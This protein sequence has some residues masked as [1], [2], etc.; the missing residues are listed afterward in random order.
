M[1]RSSLAAGNLAVLIAAMLPV[2]G[3]RADETRNMIRRDA[4]AGDAMSQR[5]YAIML[6]YEY[7]EEGGHLDAREWRETIEPEVSYEQ[8]NRAINTAPKRPK[9]KTAGTETRLGK[10]GPASKLTQLPIDSGPERT[11]IFQKLEAL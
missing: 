3:L 11:P 2:S 7:A 1:S 4:Y 9:P 10:P 5:I 8:R 6:S